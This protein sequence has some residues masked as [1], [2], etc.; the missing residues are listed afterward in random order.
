MYKG[1]IATIAA[2]CMAM[3]MATALAQ[4]QAPPAQSGML[5]VDC[6]NQGV[7]TINTDKSEVNN[8]HATIN[9]TSIE[10]SSAEGVP[11]DIGNGW[12][13][14]A[15]G[16]Y[17]LDRVNGTLSVTL[18]MWQVDPSGKEIGHQLS[19]MSSNTC[20]KSDAPATKF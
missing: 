13:G 9:A 10:W 12:T 8:R 5:Y 11:A 2:A 18:D 15:Q 19:P 20:R 1:K 16:H 3:A 17:V 14:H 7:L 6:G 4:Q